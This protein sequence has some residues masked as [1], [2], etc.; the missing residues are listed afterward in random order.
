[1]IGQR[2]KMVLFMSTSPLLTLGRSTIIITLLTNVLS[3]QFQKTRVSIGN[4]KMI[5]SAILHDFIS[6]SV[7]V[8]QR[9]QFSE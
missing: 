8:N 6:Y 7:A 5:F 3:E 4:Y 1:M 9:D 2:N